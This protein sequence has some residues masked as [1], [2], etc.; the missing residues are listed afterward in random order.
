VTLLI[1]N[2]GSM[3]GRPITVAAMSADILAP[4]PGA[5]R[6]QGRDPRLYDRGPGRAARR[7]RDGS[8]PA[9]RP[10]PAGS[11]ICGTSSTSRPTRRGA[12]PAQ[13]RA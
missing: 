11:T 7:A 5:L 9:S 3:R 8:P 10:T 13:S 1:D 4:H 2:S 12:A 6:R